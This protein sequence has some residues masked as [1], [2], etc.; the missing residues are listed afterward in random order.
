VLTHIA[1]NKNIKADVLSQRPDYQV[2]DAD[3]NEDQI[4]LR[5]EHFATIAAT[6]VSND[7]LERCIR[8][9]VEK[10]VE[11]LQGMESLQRNGPK[12]LTDGTLEWEE[13]QGLV[14]YKEKLYVPNAPDLRRDIVK[15]CHDAITV[16]HPGRSRTIWGVTRFYWW[17]RMKEFITKYTDGCDAC[18]RMKAATHPK[19]TLQPNE[20]PE[21][22]WQTIG[23]D[24]IVVRLVFLPVLHVW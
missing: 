6:Y 1:G 21:G 24:F 2:S 20:I 3:D 18:Q 19:A 12:R 7:D 14:Y 13:L 8:D 22:P 16:G 15:Q 5:P 10:E 23:V 9:A 17:P 11:V 4:V